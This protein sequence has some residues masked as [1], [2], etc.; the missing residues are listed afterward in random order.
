MTDKLR[1]IAMRPFFWLFAVATMLMAGS[2]A[3]GYVESAHS[4]GRLA[5][6]HCGDTCGGNGC[7]KSCGCSQ[8]S[9]YEVTGDEN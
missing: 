4:R 6:A 2:A 3:Q 8:G 9:C 7:G 5:V 1:K